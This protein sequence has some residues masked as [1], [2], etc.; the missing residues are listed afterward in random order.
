M[1]TIQPP[2]LEKFT[3]ETWEKFKTEYLVYTKKGGKK[4]F[5]KCIDPIC[6]SIISCIVEFT[7]VTKQKDSFDEITAVFGKS[8][9]IA[10]YD[11]LDACKMKSKLDL[12]AYLEYVHGFKRI[13]EANTSKGSESTVVKKFVQ[14]LYSKR[15][16]ERTW[17]SIDESTATESLKLAIKCGFE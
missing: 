11:A 12:E 7:D 14:N 8:S 13:F 3:E 2:I 6:W 4:S 5:D 17:A 9:T 10:Y 1:A 15:F 16:R